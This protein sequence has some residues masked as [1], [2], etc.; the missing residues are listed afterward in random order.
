M[1]TCQNMGSIQDRHAA[2]TSSSLIVP[3]APMAA[4]YTKEGAHGNKGVAGVFLRADERVPERV[5]EL[6]EHRFSEWLPRSDYASGFLGAGALPASS[7]ERPPEARR[8]K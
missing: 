2:T 3:M 7:K 1:A 6:M 4:S 5:G 8:S